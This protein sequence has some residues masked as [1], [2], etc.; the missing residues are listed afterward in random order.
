MSKGKD[1]E[2][3]F[4]K[5]LSSQF[6]VYRL[7]DTLGYGKLANIADYIAY[8]YP[9]IYLLEMKTTAG[10]SLPFANI[11]E[12]QWNGLLKATNVEGVISGFPVW[13]YDKGV[14]RFFSI[15][16]LTTIDAKSVRYDSDLGITIEGTRRRVFFDYDIDKFYKDTVSRYGIKTY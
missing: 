1:F 7:Y 12:T 15:Q 13:F 10:A 11:S 8:K 5:Q 9:Y 2:K 6:F 4:S 16:E 14:T 3:E